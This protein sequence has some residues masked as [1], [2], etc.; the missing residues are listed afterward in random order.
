M[1]L[2][3]TEFNIIRATH[4]LHSGESR[5]GVGA[6]GVRLMPISQAEGQSF[7]KTNDISVYKVLLA[8]E[9]TF[10]SASLLCG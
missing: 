8:D 2:Y 4:M 3:K 9:N 6:E 10:S 5:K 7:L 1:I